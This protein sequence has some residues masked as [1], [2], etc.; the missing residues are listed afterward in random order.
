MK[1]KDLISLL[2]LLENQDA[3]VKIGHINKSDY[4]KAYST[5]LN[6]K[7]TITESDSGDGNG[8]IEYHINTIYKI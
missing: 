2:C 3:E 5:D 8:T 7:A 1:V 4:W 6:N